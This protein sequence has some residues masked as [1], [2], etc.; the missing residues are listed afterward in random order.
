MSKHCPK[1]HQNFSNAFD[2]CVYC[3]SELDDGAFIEN[4]LPSKPKHTTKS[5]YLKVAYFDLSGK[6][7]SVELECSNCKKIFEIDQG[8]EE[9][10]ADIASDYITIKK[11]AIIKCSCGNVHPFSFITFRNNRLSEKDDTN[12]KVSTNETTYIPR[13]PI[14]Q[15]PDIKK[16]STA[17]KISSVALWG[18]FS[19][20]AKK[21]WHCNNCGSEW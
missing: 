1:C 14:C 17:S 18:V 12:K 19:Q 6:P 3:G 13:C 7:V 4:N 2:E 10:F 5:I 9:L 20:K 8:L 11:G 15:S 21:Q 16:I